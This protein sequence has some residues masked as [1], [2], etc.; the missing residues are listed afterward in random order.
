MNLPYFTKSS[1][2]VLHIVKKWVAHNIPVASLFF[3][4]WKHV[5][6]ELFA[7]SWAQQIQKFWA[8]YDDAIL[9]IEIAWDEFLRNRHD[10]PVTVLGDLAGRDKM[11]AFHAP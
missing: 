1:R 3:I 9:R 5:L 7:F 2:F 8:D 10:L 6:L 4:L 11:A